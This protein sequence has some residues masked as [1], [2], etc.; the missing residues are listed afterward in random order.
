MRRANAAIIRENHPLSTMDQL[1][2]RI[3]EAKLFSKLDIQQTFHQ[4]EIMP[5]SRHI[6]TFITSKGLYR[7]KRLMFGISCAPKIYQKVM[8]KLLITYEGTINFIDDILVF[9][10]DEVEHN[11]RLDHTLKVLREHNVL[12]NEKKC[13]YKLKE[14][15]TNIKK[16]GYYKPEDKTQVIADASP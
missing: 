6:T 2:P 8:E 5:S 7:Y 16:L 14:A 9:G 1:L 3:R 12:L 13:A 11:H 10:S 15:L 4:I